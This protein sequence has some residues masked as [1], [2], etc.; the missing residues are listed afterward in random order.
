M[1]FADHQEKL[2]FAVGIPC[3]LH[4]HERLWGLVG[5]GWE[6]QTPK[7]KKKKL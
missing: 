7:K 1:G 3:H 2:T 4:H 5:G 6:D